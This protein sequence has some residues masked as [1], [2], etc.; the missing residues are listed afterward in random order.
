MPL[1]FKTL[2]SDDPVLIPDAVM[3]RLRRGY[4]TV[5]R[6]NFILTRELLRLLA[7]LDD[8]G[9]VA[10]P[11]K[12]ALLAAIAYGDPSLRQFADLDILVRRQDVLEAKRL[13]EEQEYGARFIYGYRPLSRLS[14]AQTDVFLDNYLEFEM[15]RK[16]GLLIDLHWQFA[17]RHYPF[18]MDP[19]PLLA[20][21]ETF[22]IEGQSVSSFARE[23]QVLLLCLHG[24]KDRWTKLLWM[25]DLARFIRAY[26]GLDWDAICTRAKDS[27]MELPLL[28]GL[29][30]AETL[31]PCTVPPSVTE[32]SAHRERIGRMAG[33]VFANLFEQKPRAECLPVNALHLRLCATRID[34]VTY[35]S[36]GLCV[37][38]VQE[39]SLVRLPAWLYPLYYVIRPFRIMARCARISVER[40]RIALARHA[41]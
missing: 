17:P 28:L 25:I 37:P 29:D 16:D 8:H 10:V 40:L 2:S 30:L 4:G 20:R 15:Q 22:R 31:F 19:D 21:L 32:R 26:P 3:D 23:D 13:L 1:L 6:R 27:A 11:Y 34:Q 39:W 12:G 7:C 9:I 41:R 33:S 18:R 38:R 24:A 35:L 5:S 36:R 14:P